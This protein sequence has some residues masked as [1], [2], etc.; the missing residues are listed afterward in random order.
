MNQD[1]LRKHVANYLQ[2]EERSY[3]WLSRKVGVS[4]VYMLNWKNGK[5]KLSDKRVNQIM[6]FIEV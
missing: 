3:S 2:D 6:E 1:A 5:E 4:K